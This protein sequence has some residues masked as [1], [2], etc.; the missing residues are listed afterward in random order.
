MTTALPPYADPVQIDREAEKLF[1]EQQQI[2]LQ[3]TDRL[4]GMLLALQW[5]ACIVLALWISPRAWA[6][7]ESTTHPHVLAALILGSIVVSLPL[8]LVVM[9]P[10]HMITRHTVA[11][12]QMLMGGLLI[13]LTGGRI[14]THFHVFGSLAFLAFYR[15]WPVLVSAS[16]VV[17]ADHFLRGILWPESIFGVAS[18][19]SWRILEHAFWVVFC[20]VFLIVACLQG[21]RDLRIST[22]RQAELE[23]TKCRIE[24]TVDERTAELQKAMETV[25]A[26]GRAKSE[27]LANMSHEIRTPMNGVI[28]MTE[29]ALDTELTGEQ[30]EYLSLVKSS[31]ESLL[32]LLNDIL[33]F[34]K[35]E[36]GKL[37]LDPIPFDL[38]DCVD[39]VVKVLGFRAEQKG[40][41]LVSDIDADVPNALIGD[42]GRLRQ[43]L[44]NLIGNA[45]KFTEEGEIVVRLELESITKGEACLHFAVQDTGI[46]IPA[47]KHALIFEAFT[48]VDALP[49]RAR[50]WRH[51]PGAQY[52]ICMQLVRLMGGRM[53]VESEL[54]AGSTFHFT[55]NLKRQFGPA[56]RP[57][58]IKAFHAA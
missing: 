6:G 41:E 9:K 55:A 19:A 15:D 37:D 44:V 20:D 54:D 53:W 56:A 47:D 5:V 49:P 34:S 21:V 43:V 11:I 40:I 29:L 28:G 35:I 30:R 24:Q 8:W 32:T 13:H 48:Q 52:C 14:E 4:F 3:R 38:R 33:D 12:A 10:G 23:A 50:V 7:M 36:A 18:S 2:L 51:G 16:V 46:G 25:E 42:A 45:V 17:V 58:S 31:A 27:F 39:D 1:H 22:R 57:M 26:A